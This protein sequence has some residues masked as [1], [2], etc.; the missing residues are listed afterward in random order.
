MT[1]ILLLAILSLIGLA[2]PS[3][4]PVSAQ[5]TP[6]TDIFGMSV[7][8]DGELLAMSS[9]YGVH[10]YDLSTGVIIYGLENEL[11]NYGQGTIAYIGWSPDGSNL[12]VGMPTKGVRIWDTASWE[13]LAEQVPNVGD[14]DNPGFAWSPDG[15]QLALGTGSQTGE[16]LIWDKETNSWDTLTAYTGQQVSLVWTADDELL[17][18]A[19][20]AFYDAYTGELVRDFFTPID[21]VSGYA[22]WSPD[23]TLV[24]VFFDLGGSI[25]NSET[26][27]S[28]GFGACCYAEVA[29]S[30][31]GHY[32]AAASFGD[33]ELWVWDTQADEVVVQERQGD[34]IYAFAWL[35]NDELLAAG[36]M[37]GED[38]IWNTTTGEVLIRL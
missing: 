37:N 18:M 26:N 17:V 20:Q 9:A 2:H 11:E 22:L 1:R 15:S 34:M 30:M 24:Y 35:L 7:S 31:D 28:E 32:F 14:R 23:K 4:L 12:A 5:S 6:K 19:A 10:I 29:W 36:S 8:P 16:I 3:T 27:T 13:I 21:G 25:R 38:V 33:N